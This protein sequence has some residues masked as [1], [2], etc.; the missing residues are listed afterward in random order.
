VIAPANTGNL[1]IN[2]IAVI[3]TD[4]R[5]KGKRSREI[6]LVVREQIIV[7]RKLIL[8]RIDETPAR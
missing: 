3:D 6:I 2:R 8:P 4:H 1:V 7:E 5:N